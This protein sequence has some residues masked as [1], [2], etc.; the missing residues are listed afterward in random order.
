[1]FQLS[2]STLNRL[3]ETNSV[4]FDGSNRVFSDIFHRVSGNYLL[5]ME[6]PLK[7]AASLWMLYV[8]YSE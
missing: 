4:S 3:K 8:M 7:L 5:Q 6:A 1:V 2:V